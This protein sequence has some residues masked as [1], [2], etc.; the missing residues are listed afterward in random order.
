EIGVAR[1]LAARTLVARTLVARTLVAA[2][3]AIAVLAGG[4]S[5]AAAQLPADASWRTIESTNFRVTY[6]AGLESLARHATASAERAY[7]ALEA[8]VA[9]APRGVIDIVLADNLDL[10]NGYATPFPTN[11]IVVYAKPPVDV[12]ELQYTRDW[13]ELVVTHELAHIFHLDVTSGFGRILRTAFGRAPLPWPVFPAVGVPLWSVEGLAVGVESAVTGL[14]RVHGSYHEMVVR[15]A[16]LAGALDEFDR[17]GAASARWP[18]G[19]RVYIY[20]S[21]FMD[22]VARRYGTDAVARVV[23]STAGAVIPP[24]LWFGRV[25]SNALGITFRDAYRDWQRETIA[26]GDSLARLL[27]GQGLTSGAILTDHRAIALYPRFSPDGRRV[28]YAA[29]DWRTPPRLRVIDS[30]SGAQRSSERLNQPAGAAWVSADRLITSDID[31]V[32]RFRAFG[33]LYLAGDGRRRLTRGQRLQEPDV[34]RDGR[35]VAVQNAGGTNRLVLV[36]TASGRVAPITEYDRDTH[37]ALPRFAPSGDRIAVSRWTTGG[38]YDIVVMDTLGTAIVATDGTGIN[39]GP[40][41]SPDGRWILFS[42][43]RTGIANLYAA[44]VAQLTR[45]AAPGSAARPALRQVTNVLTGAF[46]PDV[47]PDGSSIIYA[48]YTHDGFRIERL[49]FDTAQWRTPQPAGLTHSFA[50]RDDHG[51]GG[52]VIADS[53]AAAF[54]T[55]DTLAGV[56]R[57]YN[58]ARSLRPHFWLPYIESGVI[59]DA[60]FLGLWTYG[61]DLVGRHSWQATFAVETGRGRTQGGL[62][63]TFHGLPTIPGVNLHPALSARI[64]RDWDTYFPASG[65]GEPYADERE[66]LAALSLDLVRARWRSTSGIGVA[67]ERV[68]RSRYL[69]DASPDLSLIDP[70]DDL[71]GVRLNAF[72]ARFVRPPLSISRED[73]YTLQVTGRQRREREVRTHETDA[74]TITFDASYREITSW[75]TAYLALP[76]PGFARHVLALRF[77]GLLRDGPGASISRVGGAGGDGLTVPGVVSGLGGSSTLLPVRGFESGARF[78]SNA[79]TASFEYRLPVVLIDAALR[80]L[81]LDRISAAAFVDAGHAWCSEQLAARFTACTSTSASHASLIGV[82]AETTVFLGFLGLHAPLRLGGGVPVRGSVNKTPRAYV[83]IGHWF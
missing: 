35:I 54:T 47:S 73:G 78:G 5:S 44:D 8:L 33:D 77:S 30:E 75:N 67:A 4:P 10:S 12:L 19:A 71:W 29:H 37:W 57:R 51:R 83:L 72:T 15:T 36:D 20:G 64:D 45:D 1:A 81:F 46:H 24:P 27:E 66:D 6:E 62:S 56:A 68:Q 55:P 70:D 25:G 14:G 82:G 38:A 39:A 53:V 18:G 13:I 7:G 76:L 50:P 65:P 42:S 58:P 69:Y 17:L 48:A 61:Q 3:V 60:T 79:W 28:A 32:D 43:D 31:F 40:A 16:A 23:R 26:L 80:P 34:S 2:G 41:W 49:P 21:L 22:Y 9:E 63:Y 11:R 74:G 52:G 59:D